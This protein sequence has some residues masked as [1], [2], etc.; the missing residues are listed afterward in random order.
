[1]LGNATFLFLGCHHSH[2][3]GLLSIWDPSPV[4]LF[5][6]LELLWNENTEPDQREVCSITNWN[7]WKWKAIPAQ[8]CHSLLLPLQLRWESIHCIQWWEE[9]SA[10][11]R[12]VKYYPL[13]GK[14]DEAT[15][16]RGIRSWYML[17][18][19]RST[20][21]IFSIETF[22]IHSLPLFP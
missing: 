16:D 15:W 17:V 6:P 8:S 11:R 3:K 2:R 9:Q 1:M 13:L 21:T 19:S 5:H 14:R 20:P 10:S 12:Q 7:Q 18:S 4:A 22:P